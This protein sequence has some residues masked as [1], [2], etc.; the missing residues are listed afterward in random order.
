MNVGKWLVRIASGA[1]SAALAA[2]FVSCQAQG[3]NPGSSEPLGV[4]RQASTGVCDSS[5]TAPQACI[6]AIQANGGK[7]VND[8]FKDSNGLTAAQLPLFGQVFNAYPGCDTIVGGG[9]A[10]ASLMPYDCPGQYSC[11]AMAPTLA[12][13]AAYM[14]SLDRLWWQPCRLT[15]HNLINGCPNWASCTADGVGGNYFPWEGIVFD[16]GGPS[17]KVAIF[18]EN[19]HGPQPCESLEYTVYLTDNPYAK[20]KIEQPAVTG[21]DPQKWNRAVLSTIFTKGFVEVRPPDPVGYAACG[22]TALYSVEE[23]SFAQVFSL[24]CGITFRYASILAG[25]DGLD[26]PECAF[27]SADAELD[28]VAGLTEGGGGVCPDADGDHFVDCN[29]PVAPPSCDCN[30]ADAD[31]H[32]GAPEACDSPDLNCDN[33]PGSCEAGLF[34]NNSICIPPCGSGETPCPVGSTCVN[35]N[36]GELCVPD[37]CSV[38]GCPPG[39]ICS[40]GICVPACDNVVCPGKMVCQD[41]QCV[42]PCKGVECPTPQV[43][44]AGVCTAPC[45]CFA[46]N[47]GCVGLPGTVCDKGNTDLC[48][49]PACVGVTC[50][51]GEYCDPDT[52]MCV[53]FCNEDVNCPVGQKCVAPQGC[54]PLCEGVTC[55]PG[56]TCDPQTGQCVDTSCDGVVCFEGEH[57]E[58]GVCVPD[59]GTG[60]SG[61]GGTGAAGGAGGGGATAGGS[62]GKQDPGDEGNCGCRTVGQ[63]SNSSPAAWLVA[64]GLVIAASRRK[65]TPA[66]R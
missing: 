36:Q 60:G 23:D 11:T 9:C 20:E 42:D 3:P 17:N 43:C 39:S 55:D 1:A 34:C 25:N 14:N 18:A 54:V 61:G 19:D 65:R 45:D 27:D 32:P 57:C 63:S 64:L 22:D 7:V 66:R 44:Q 59:A 41:G 47:A 56:L 24:P 38:G 58:N 46:D 30:D 4:V 33:A 62:G 16:L 50:N 21:V 15:D 51:P 52:S 28:A 13:G 8:I 29:C 26:F 35:T 49:D 48:V 5:P 40:N 2:V 37:D 12:N 31:V 53:P 10:G 6:D